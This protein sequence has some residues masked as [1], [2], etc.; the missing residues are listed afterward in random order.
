MN[1]RVPGIRDRTGVKKLRGPSRESHLR[2]TGRDHETHKESHLAAVTLAAYDHR[3]L[4][5]IV[6]VHTDDKSSLWANRSTMHRLD[7][8]VGKDNAGV[9]SILDAPLLDPR[10][11]NMEV[12]LT[13]T[14]EGA[15]HALQNGSRYVLRRIDSTSIGKYTKLGFVPCG[16]ANKGRRGQVDLQ[17]IYLDF[18][19]VSRLAKVESPLLAAAEAVFGKATHVEDEPD[20][21]RPVSVIMDPALAAANRPP[22]PKAAAAPKP[23]PA[24]TH[25]PRPTPSKPLTG[26]AL[27]QRIVALHEDRSVRGSAFLNHIPRDQLE[28]FIRSGRILTIPGG[29][30]VVSAGSR[31]RNVWVIL[32]GS[33]ELRRGT[34]AFG[35]LRTGDVIGEMAFLR[36][37]DHKTQVYAREGSQ[38]LELRAEHLD[39]VVA[40]SAELGTHVAMGLAA[41]L[42]RKMARANAARRP[43]A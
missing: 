42:S 39:K 24:P 20:E 26:R 11:G 6:D 27:W 22:P 17:P 31:S 33:V 3:G 29:D 12:E 10:L 35:A 5:G 34:H 32:Q 36:Q 18:A 40:T 28:G 7:Y 30:C 15:L 8:V 37:T 2:L 23:K 38:L 41:A 43:R 13:L 1:V 4:L 25:A 16:L 19:D 9:V 21:D 14:R